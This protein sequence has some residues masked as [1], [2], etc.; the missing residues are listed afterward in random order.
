MKLSS[1]LVISVARIGDTILLTPCLKAIKAT[2]PEATL[3]V[4]AHPK[5]KEVLENLEFIDRLGAIT[6]TVAMW[7]GWWPGK[8]YDIALVYGRDA[9]LVK[10]ALRVAKSVVCFAEPEFS[11]IEDRAL[12]KV[13]TP[14]GSIHAI[15]HRLL[16]LAPIGI[17][18]IAD[19]RLA[20]RF[21][22][23][24]RQ[25][26][27]V[28]SLA[29]GLAGRHPLI[30]LQAFSFPA[31]AHRDWPLESFAALISRVKALHPSSLFVILGDQLAAERAQALLQRF[32]DCLKIVAGQLNLRQ[33]AAFMA[34]LDLYVGVDTGPT[35][36]AGALGI[37][38]VAMYHWKY[39]A[40]NLRPLQNDRCRA[41]EHPATKKPDAG[42]PDGMEAIAV[43]QVVQ[44]A[45]S[46]LSNAEG[47]SGVANA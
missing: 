30:G 19:Q 6:K 18:E 11:T 20:M 40:A 44:A 35:H 33:S 12:I 32:P 39:P 17:T 28:F 43:E 37:P 15:D 29:Q 1:V 34:R 10:Y 45:L 22:A 26:A 5:R 42:F 16:L 31:K 47:R 38:M 41:I 2:Y 14:T 24:E 21:T 7:K 8:P 4:L 3:T 9:A 27:E 36:I 23:A 46:L 25:G 13:N